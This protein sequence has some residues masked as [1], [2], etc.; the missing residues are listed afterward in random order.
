[1]LKK[2]GEDMDTSLI[3]VSTF[4]ALARLES[5]QPLLFLC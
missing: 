3:F 2:Y 1:M 4:A 5:H